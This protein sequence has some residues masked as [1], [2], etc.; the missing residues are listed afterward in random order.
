MGKS[1]QRV[2]EYRNYKLPFEFPVLLLHGDRWHISDKKADVLHIHNCLEI[3]ICH[4]DGGIIEYGDS[5]CSFTAGDITCISQNIP[6]TTYSTKGTASL[7][8]YL[9]LQ[10]EELMK[11]YLADSSFIAKKIVELDQKYFCVIHKK[12]APE[13]YQLV[14]QIIEE[15]TRKE[16]DYQMSVTGLFVSLFIRL[17]RIGSEKLPHT[18][19][20]N[21]KKAIVISPALDY[22]H[23]NYMQQFS[24]D[25]LACLCHLSPTHFRRIFHTIMNTS[26][27]DYLN[28]Y[29]ILKACTLLRSTEDS[30]LAVSEQVGFCSISSF[31]RHFDAI[32]GISPTKWRQTGSDDT[33]RISI[34]QYN[35]WMD[36]TPRDF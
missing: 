17:I 26:P 7:W 13:V 1:K 12:D 36:D 28:T 24:I 25:T 11:H 9:F 29:R 23:Q 21:S 31:N 33:E 3:G 27:L 34:L 32:M 35:G 18:N 16:D 19:T 20:Q 30:I 14:L 22:I 15:L 10:P 2:I 4:S 5:S 6:H 8:S